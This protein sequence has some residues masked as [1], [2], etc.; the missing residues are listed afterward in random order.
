MVTARRAICTHRAER[1]GEREEREWCSYSARSLQ[2]QGRGGGGRGVATSGR[3]WVLVRAIVDRDYGGLT[4][5]RVTFARQR[6][7]ELSAP[8]LSYQSLLSAVARE[9]DKQLKI[10]NTCSHSESVRRGWSNLCTSFSFSFSFFRESYIYVN[11]DKK[12]RIFPMMNPHP[13]KNYTQ[14]QTFLPL[15]VIYN[16]PPVCRL[17]NECGGWRGEGRERE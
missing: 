5:A 2:V 12:L 15:V 6:R 17:E 3:G 14:Y 4:G 9:G 8:T 16:L 11:F 10:Y 13:I 7:G 1:E